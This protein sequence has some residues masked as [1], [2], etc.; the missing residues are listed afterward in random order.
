MKPARRPGQ[1]LQDVREHRL[2]VSRYCEDFHDPEAAPELPLVRHSALRNFVAFTRRFR[3][4]C[5][6]HAIERLTIATG[7]PI[8]D[9]PGAGQRRGLFGRRQIDKLIRDN[10]SDGGNGGKILCRMNK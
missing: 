8:S 10:S 3:R 7:R 2:P 6:H 9:D 4:D 1:D 5:R